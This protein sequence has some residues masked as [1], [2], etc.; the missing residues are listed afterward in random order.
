MVYF[1]NAAT[2]FPKPNSVYKKWQQA[3]T[4][5]GANPGRGGYTLAQKTGEAV[6]QSRLKCAEFFGAEAENAVFTLNC[7]HSLNFAIKGL[8]QRGKHFVISDLEHNA[9][10]RPIN[11]VAENYGCCFEEY[12]R[13]FE[14]AFDAEETLRNANNV[15]DGNTAAV[16][17]TAASN[18]IGLRN[19]LC[20]L[21]RLCR[22]RNVPFVVDAAQGAGLFPINLRCADIICAAG[23][24]GLYAPMG[25]GLLITNGRYPLRT[26]IEG[27]T[28]SVSESIEQPDFMPDRFESGTINTAGAI[29]L[30]EGVSFVKSM[31]P[32]RILSHELALCRRFCNEARKLRKV[33][34]YNV[35]DERNSHLF[36]PV[37]SFVFEG[38]PAIEGAEMLGNMGFAMRGG[39]H[40]A[41]FA[42]KKIGTLENGTIRFAPSVFNTQQ[43]VDALIRA[44]SRV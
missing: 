27:G 7:T 28:G 17:C 25:T 39:L 10:V 38:I 34:L 16:V 22:E 24:K 41:P 18:V 33:R 20:E 26:L 6:F 35:I 9:V 37:V 12:C 23:H 13:V 31:T 21:Y 30:G 32:Q 36:A 14:T 42:H 19:P 5:Y 1:D 15:I 11:A 44:M 3:M 2:T 29:A 40:C 8:A 43:E 4:A